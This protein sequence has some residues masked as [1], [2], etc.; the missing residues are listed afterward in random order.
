LLFLILRTLPAPSTSPFFTGAPTRVT[1]STFQPFNPRYRSPNS[2]AI[3]AANLNE[4]RSVTPSVST[5]NQNPPTANE[6]PSRRIGNI[7]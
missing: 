5:P 7:N 6:R 4:R 2:R 3:A 1:S